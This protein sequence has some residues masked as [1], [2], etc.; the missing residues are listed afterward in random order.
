MADPQLPWLEE[1]SGQT[2]DQLI[3]LEGKYRTDSIIVAFEQAMDQKAA[4]VGVAKLSDEERI[5]LAVEALEREVNNGGYAQ[6]FVNSSH[7]YAPIIVDAL[8]RIG[9]PATAK[10]T[11]RA[12]DAAQLSSGPIAGVTRGQWVVNE[13][14]EKALADCDTLYFGG[15]DNIADQLFAFIKT[16]K[17]KIA[18]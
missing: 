15:Q 13:D 7:E 3:A 14:C 1:Y 10:I 9:C 16:N 17:S 12:V 5:I 2:V 6:F 4:R 18:P 8:L 11:Q